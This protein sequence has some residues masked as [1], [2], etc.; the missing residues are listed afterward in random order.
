M[1]IHPRDAIIALAAAAMLAWAAAVA[2]AAEGALPSSPAAPPPSAAA[3]PVAAPSPAAPLP[4]DAVYPEPLKDLGR[5][6]KVRLVYFVPKDR[7]PIARWREKIA[8]V[9]TFVNDLYA[10]DLR[11]KGYAGAGLDFEFDAGGPAVHLLAGKETAAHYNGDPAFD[12]MR[13]WRLIIPEVEA[14]LGKAGKQVYVIFAETYD[15]GPTPFEWRGGFALGARFSTSG[16]VGMFS[17]W[18]L[19]DE[20]CATTV[21]G[22][23]RLLADDT[24]IPGRTANHGRRPDSPRFEFIEDGLGA[25]AHE[26]GHAFGLP[27]DLR[28]DNVEIMAN[29]FRWL[30]RNYLPSKGGPGPTAGFLMDTARLFRWSRYLMADVDAADTQAPQ[31]RL[32]T[33]S[34]LKAG[35]THFYVSAD[36]TDDRGLAA[37]A[38]WLPGR[39]WILAGGDLV[40]TQVALKQSLVVPP[41]EKGPMELVL[42]IMDRGGN[43]A[44]VKTKIEV[45]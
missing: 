18:I 19:R 35:T 10:R 38:F 13:Q 37:Y 1:P 41:L 15:D 14:A 6:F 34:R 2:C 16:G 30:R 33:P 20:F 31:A 12:G 44:T 39:D 7:Q 42:L 32:E 26:L 24:P 4:A 27:H 3:P 9:M 36:V 25:V 21:E 17:A 22:E 11:S 8:V 40:G 45:E 29:G 5:A 28:V 43:L 23:L